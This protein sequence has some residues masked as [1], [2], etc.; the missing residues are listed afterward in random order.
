[1][2]RRP[3]SSTLFPYTTLFRSPSQASRHRLSKKPNPWSSFAGSRKASRSKQQSPLSKQL[4]STLLMILKGS[5]P[6][7]RKGYRNKG[8]REYGNRGIREYGNRVY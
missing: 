6:L 8:I 1:M 3:P 2:I 5:F 4:L 7:S